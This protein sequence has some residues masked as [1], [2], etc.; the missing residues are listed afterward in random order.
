MPQSKELELN[1]QQLGLGLAYLLFYLTN[2]G[3]VAR[4]F[5]LYMLNSFPQFSRSAPGGNAAQR[6]KD[7]RLVGEVGVERASTAASFRS[8]VPNARSRKA[9]ARK[10]HLC[11]AQQLGPG[12]LRLQRLG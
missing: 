11:G 6:K 2:N 4:C 7:L 12:P 8:N 9:I 5:I 1:L 10:D 3:V